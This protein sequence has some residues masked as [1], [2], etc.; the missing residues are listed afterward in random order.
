MG[1]EFLGVYRLDSADF[2]LVVPDMDMERLSMEH[3]Q[4]AVAR[5]QGLLNDPDALTQRAER[6]RDGTAK[7]VEGLI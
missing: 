3:L 1:R 6:L 2:P 4:R 7:P 5:I